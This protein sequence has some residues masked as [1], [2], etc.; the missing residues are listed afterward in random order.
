MIDI[1]FCTNRVNYAIALDGVGAGRSRPALIFIEPWRFDPRPRSGVRHLRIGI[2][3]YRLL[4]ALVRLRVVATLHLPHHRFNRRVLWCLDH[5][6]RV[7]YLDDGLDTLRQRPSNFDLNLIKGRPKYH[8]FVEYLNVP[9]WLQDFELQRCMSIRG[10]AGLDASLPRLPL[11]KVTHLFIESPGLE[12]SRWIEALGLS[13]SDVLVVRHPV[14]SKRATLPPDCPFIEG[15]G[16]DLEATL[17]TCRGLTI[18]CGETLVLVFAAMTECARF[19]RVLA[20]MRQPSRARLAGLSWRDGGAW[21]DDL[22]ELACVGT[23]EA[24]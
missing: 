13:L 21:G 19:N 17:L 9:T 5:V 20:Q 6:P 16:H 22:L 11:D 3:A 18:Y 23:D 2:W 15:A 14:P 8:T 7:D 24:S 4:R 1:F 10:L 12:P